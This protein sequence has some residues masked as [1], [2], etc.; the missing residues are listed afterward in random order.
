MKLLKLI[1]NKN[2]SNRKRLQN[3]SKSKERKD[4]IALTAKDYLIRTR[5]RS[6]EIKVIGTEP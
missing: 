3:G 2:L 6:I 1:K 5:D 4:D